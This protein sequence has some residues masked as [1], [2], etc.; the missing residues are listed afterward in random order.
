MR[1]ILIVIEKYCSKLKLTFSK[2]YFHYCYIILLIYYFYS[3]KIVDVKVKYNTFNY[4]VCYSWITTIK[5]EV[6]DTLCNLNCT[7][8]RYIPFLSNTHLYCKNE[9][10]SFK[11]NMSS[12]NYRI[13]LFNTSTYGKYVK[14]YRFYYDCIN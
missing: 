8:I 14:Q 12:T 13:Y 3:V 7:Y 4:T 11:N 6:R 10:S 5:Y 2:L 9:F 1:R